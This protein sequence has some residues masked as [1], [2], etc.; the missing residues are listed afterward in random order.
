MTIKEVMEKNDRTLINKMR[1]CK[2]IEEFKMV[3]EENGIEVT[4]EEMKRISGTLRNHMGG[5]LSDDDLDRVA[6]GA[7]LW[8][9]PGHYD[10]IKCENPDLIFF[11]PCS[12][13]Q[14]RPTGKAYEV[15]KSCTL[16]GWKT[17]VYESPSI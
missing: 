8:G 15:E 11:I 1:S 17:I 14:S 16:H 4:E 9:C 13:L 3:A 2:T 10:H 7:L 6:G 12:H 5:E